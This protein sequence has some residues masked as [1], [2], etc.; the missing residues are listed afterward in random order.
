[1]TDD[2]WLLSSQSLYVGRFDGAATSSGPEPE[3]PDP[4]PNHSFYM[5]VYSA[6]GASGPYRVYG[7]R[8]ADGQTVV[9][10]TSMAGL[11][12]AASVV[13]IIITADGVTAV[14]GMAVLGSYLVRRELR[15]LDRVARHADAL[16]AQAHEGLPDRLDVPEYPRTTA[17]A[18]PTPN[19]PTCSTASTAW[20]R[21]AAA[22]QAAAA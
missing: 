16:A 14:I 5:T 10:A 19:C 7:D 11:Q 18:S 3:L 2:R 22:Q 9:V 4:L 1:M 12:H 21:A 20:T 17:P 15:P 13:S 6:D 8:T